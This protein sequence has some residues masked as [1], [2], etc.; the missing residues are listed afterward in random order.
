MPPEWLTGFGSGL[1]E[2]DA[3][4]L[5]LFVDIEDQCFSSDCLRTQ[6]YRSSNL[7]ISETN[8]ASIGGDERLIACV[9]MAHLVSFNRAARRSRKAVSLA[10]ACSSAP[11]TRASSITNRFTRS[12]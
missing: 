8:V 7:T 3:N 4:N 9:R 12:G 11:R 2:F 10:S 6:N 5:P 1:N